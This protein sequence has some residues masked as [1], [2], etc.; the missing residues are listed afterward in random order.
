MSKL[1]Y[2][3][4]I[5]SFL[6]NGLYRESRNYF[7]FISKDGIYEFSL[8]ENIKQF[9]TIKLFE[10]LGVDITNEKEVIANYIRVQ[11]SFNKK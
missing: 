4:S 2:L 11:Q 5:F 7:K 8:T 3:I 1:S 10:D 6:F 9:P